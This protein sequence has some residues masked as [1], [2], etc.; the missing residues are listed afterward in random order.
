MDKV[1]MEPIEEVQ[2]ESLIPKP[3]IS[4]N[5]FYEASAMLKSKDASLMAAEFLKWQQ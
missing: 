5:T 4:D 1:T 2:V 3:V